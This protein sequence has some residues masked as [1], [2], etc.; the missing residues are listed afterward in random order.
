LISVIGDFT[1]KVRYIISIR[2]TTIIEG[3]VYKKKVDAGLSFSLLGLHR[4]WIFPHNGRVNGLFI[5]GHPSLV[6]WGKPNENRSCCCGYPGCCCCDSTPCSYWRCCSN[7]HH[8][9]HG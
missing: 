4:Y 6:S 8:E 3:M 9:A 5:A 2:S 1:S 7:C